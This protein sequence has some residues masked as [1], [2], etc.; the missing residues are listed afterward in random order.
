MKFD[1]SNFFDSLTQTGLL[2]TDEQRQRITEKITQVLS[3]EPKIGIFGK[4]GVGK[5][6]LCNALFGQDIAAISDIE[7][8][9]RNPQ[10]ILLK[11]GQGNSKGI[12]LVDVPGVGESQERD[13]EYAKLYAKLLPELDVV[14][15]LL[16]GD[17]RAFTS[18]EFF[19]KNVVKP[20]LD[21][22]KVFFIVVNQVDKIEPFREWDEKNHIPG[23]NQLQNI[24]AKLSVVS[25]FFSTPVSKIIAVSAGEKYN[26]VRL[27]DEIV[28]ALPKDKKVTFA[29]NVKKEN[30]SET[31][32][33]KAE[34]GFW[35]TA[36]DIVTEVI[37]AVIESIPIVG[38]FY[39]AVKGIFKL[40]F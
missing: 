39:K 8:C 36:W 21:Q 3:Y 26:L 10:E 24:D 9:T 27:I 14:L 28:F 5:S 40:F 12:K 7:A 6:S 18:D 16:K 17:D 33:T 25:R 30:V 4:T 2:I 23:P 34:K 35:D 13:Q 15:W 22:G 20:H 11:I 37:P 1:Y 19:Y 38:S 32:K 29:R 31:T